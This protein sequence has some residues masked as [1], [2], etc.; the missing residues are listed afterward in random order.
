MSAPAIPPKLKEGQF[1]VVFSEKDTGVVVRLDGSPYL[2]E[3][4]F[5]VVLD[6]YTDAEAHAIATVAQ[7][8]RLE[9]TVSDYRGRGVKEVT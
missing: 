9:A 6:S 4:D 8:A 1:S 2:G 3:G 5:F 7:C